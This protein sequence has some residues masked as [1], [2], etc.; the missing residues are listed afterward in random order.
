MSIDGIKG[1]WQ[2]TDPVAQPLAAVVFV[3]NKSTTKL[4]PALLVIKT[5]KTTYVPSGP[6]ISACRSTFDREHK[7]CRCLILMV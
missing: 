6:G 5:G 2:C 4:P 1:K 3:V 7:I